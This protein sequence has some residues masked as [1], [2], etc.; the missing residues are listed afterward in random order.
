[1][2]LS[3]SKYTLSLPEQSPIGKAHGA[4][5]PVRDAPAPLRHEQGST[6]SWN[7]WESALPGQSIIRVLEHC[8]GRTEETT[9]Q[10]SDSHYRGREAS[11][12]P[13]M[14]DCDKN[15]LPNW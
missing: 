12:E 6:S 7:S 13:G 4:H 14:S 11:A 5:V 10:L 1:M 3:N 9:A 8:A 2:P 15:R